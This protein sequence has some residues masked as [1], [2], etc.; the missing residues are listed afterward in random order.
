MILPTYPGKI[1]PRLPPNP[2]RKE[3]PNSSQKLFSETSF[4]GYLPGVRGR[5]LRV[6]QDGWGHMARYQIDVF[7]QWRD[8]LLYTS[9][10][11][12]AGCSHGQVMLRQWI[13]FHRD[14]SILLADHRSASPAAHQQE[15]PTRGR[16]R[17]HLCRLRGYPGHGRHLAGPGFR[18]HLRRG[19][20]R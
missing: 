20:T 14:S 5:D 8:R 4:K 19:W 6:Y 9:G 16:G 15:L 1:Y 13:L 2:P 10:T 17:H 3:S 12:T 18:V 7:D 11:E